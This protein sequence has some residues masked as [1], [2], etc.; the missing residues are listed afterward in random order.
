MKR[1]KH[2]FLPVFIG[3]LL[4]IM[5]ISQEE[6]STSK[7]NWKD[8][9]IEFTRQFMERN[10]RPKLIQN[11]NRGGD[12]WAVAIDAAWGPG[13][14]TAT[15]LAIFDQYW[16]TIDDHFACFQHIEDDWDALRDLYRPEIE[17]G[18][19]R[20]RF[21]AIMEQLSLSLRDPHTKVI[22]DQVHNSQLLPGVPLMV[23]GGWGDLSHFGAGLSPLPDSSLLVYDV[24]PGHALGLV[25]GDKVLGYDGIA[26]KDCYPQ[27]LEANLPILAYWWWG[28]S[29]SSFDHSFLMAA[30]MNWHLFDTIDIVKYNSGDT[31]HLPTSLLV[32]QDEYIFCT[33]QMDIPGVPKPDFFGEELVAYGIV[34]GTNI[35][36]IYCLGWF[37]DAELEFLDAV[38]TLMNDYETDGLIFDF[39]TNYGGNMFLSNP[40]LNLLFA[41]PMAYLDHSYRCDTSDHLELCSADDFSNYIF[42]EGP[43][44][45]ENPIALLTGP[46]AVS[47]GDHVALR[48]K[49]HHKARVFGKSTATAF[50][51]PTDID[52]GIAGWYGRYGET[53][54]YLLSDLDDHLTHKEFEVDEE[55]W[56]TPEAVVNGEDAVVNAA[57]DWIHS[58]TTSTKEHVK[59]EN[60]LTIFPNPVNSLLTI[61]FGDL[62]F[63]NCTVKIYNS[64]GQLVYSEELQTEELRKE[65]NLDEFST[66]AYYLTVL[67]ENWQE[68]QSFLI[69]R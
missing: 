1:P 63:Q 50:N 40:G 16:E 23:V 18:V 13:A 33:E 30:G 35:G 42:G 66:G 17:Q 43:D 68:T 54:A 38:E 4:P 62:G 19:S 58:T 20:G 64:T 60:K 27:L 46:G 21:V 65:I 5:A 57:I 39:R 12:D 11:S 37:W 24:I 51:S 10:I 9:P 69:A 45:Y 44:G 67:T 25:L 61:D 8:A 56:H 49:L 26:W 32:D 41:G 2:Y 22:F 52:F 59:P 28:G 48:L 3:V 7:T 6:Q 36:Y 55:V 47:S 29:P 53:N 31:L 34:E 15:K 14:P